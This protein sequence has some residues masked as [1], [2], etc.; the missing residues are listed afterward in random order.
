MCLI[1]WMLPKYSWTWLY[2]VQ[3]I[4][5]YRIRCNY[6]HNTEKR[7]CIPHFRKINPSQIRLKLSLH[8]RM[9][10][11]STRKCLNWMIVDNRFLSSWPKLYQQNH[12]IDR[13]T[14]ARISI[15]D[16]LCVKNR[17]SIGY[18][19]KVGDAPY[20]I[21]WYDILYGEWNVL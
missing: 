9:G 16:N 2:K 10:N 1:L 17:K 20:Y 19:K 12:F 7:Q 21:E 4:T 11:Y 3:V 6:K 5:L 8:L 18:D 13:N 15:L 14:C